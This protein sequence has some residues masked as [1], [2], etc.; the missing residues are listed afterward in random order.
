VTDDGRTIP[1]CS[2]RREDFVDD[3]IGEEI[4]SADENATRDGF[5][6]TRVQR[7]FERTEVR[8]PAAV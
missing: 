3:D 2:Y 5:C 1:R 4:E 8:E 6:T 7:D